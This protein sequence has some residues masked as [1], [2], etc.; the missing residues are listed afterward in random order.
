VEERMGHDT[1]RE[2]WHLMRDDQKVSQIKLRN[3]R[4]LQTKEREEWKEQEG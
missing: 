4:G 1:D 3:A 2:M